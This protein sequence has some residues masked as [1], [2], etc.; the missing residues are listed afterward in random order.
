[1]PITINNINKEAFAQFFLQG[2][3]FSEKA[4]YNKKII[5][6]NGTSDAK[7]KIRKVISQSWTVIS[8]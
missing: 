5:D 7:N 1:M 2:L 8:L 6:K 3:V 4:Q